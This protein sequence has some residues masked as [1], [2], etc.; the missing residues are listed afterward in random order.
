MHKLSY[1]HDS[2]HTT[3]FSLKHT[4]KTYRYIKEKHTGC[5]MRLNESITNVW[6]ES[7]QHFCPQVQ[8]V[9]EKKGQN[10][11][12]KLG[13]NTARMKTL[14]A[15][16]ESNTSQTRPGTF[17]GLWTHKKNCS[18][19]IEANHWFTSNYVNL[20]G[21]GLWLLDT[22]QNIKENI[23]LRPQ[24][25]ESEDKDTVEKRSCLSM[26]RRLDLKLIQ[27]WM[28]KIRPFVSE[29]NAKKVLM[30]FQSVEREQNISLN[31][32]QSVSL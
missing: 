28:F 32:P 14:K 5:C 21:Q 16:L 9:T 8:S 20:L 31:L 22:R 30:R 29:D 15:V 3:F 25:Q 1:A 17:Q 18:T 7:W 11:C 2:L 19:N 10:L 26:Q 27:N 23:I 13:E 12:Y 6:L 24:F 4:H